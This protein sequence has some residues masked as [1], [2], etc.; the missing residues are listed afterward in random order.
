VRCASK[1]VALREKGTTQHSR[2]RA[3]RNTPG[4]GHNGHWPQNVFFRVH[5]GNKGDAAVKFEAL[6]SA[7][8]I[9]NERLMKCVQPVQVKGLFSNHH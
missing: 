3:Q 8:Q 6:S 5:Y 7:C 4:Q 1:P 2:P 9:V